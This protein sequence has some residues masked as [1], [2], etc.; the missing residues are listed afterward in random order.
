MKKKAY[1]QPTMRV[2][3]L[4]ARILVIASKGSMPVQ[5]KYDS[6]SED[7]NGSRQGRWGDWDDGDY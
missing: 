5:V 2:I 4:S 1:I 7:P 6:T 3:E